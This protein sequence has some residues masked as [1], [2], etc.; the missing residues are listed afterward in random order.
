M[1]RESMVVKV[2]MLTWGE[3]LINLH[4][5]IDYPKCHQIANNGV[6]S[7]KI[8]YLTVEFQGYTTIAWMTFLPWPWF[9]LMFGSPIFLNGMVKKN[10]IVISWIQQNKISEPKIY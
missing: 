4:K 5:L 10:V 6:N 9:C 3:Y 7:W 1:I 2:F 8:S